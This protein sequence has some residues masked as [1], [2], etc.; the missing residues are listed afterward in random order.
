M[1]FTPRDY[2]RAIIEHALT[3][4]RANE[5]A[6]MGTGKTVSTLVVLDALYNI[7]GYS[8]PTLVLAPLRVARST[9]P[10]EV[11]KW[12]IDLT[13]SV[14][15]GNAEERERA[16]RRRAQ[17][18][19]MN[20][21]NLPWL[22]E[23]LKK[24]RMGWP[25]GNVVADESTRLKSFR[26]KQ[27][28]VRAR[29]LGAASQY[30][31]RWLNLTGT[32]SPNGLLDLWGQQWFIDQGQRLG[33]T[34]DSFKS[35][36]FHPERVGDDARA[37]K[38]IPFEHS[39]EQIQDYLRDCTLTVRAA[40]Y[41]DLPPIVHRDVR[42]QLPARAR[43]HY[44]EM[45]K[46]YFT[47]LE[48]G[49]VEAVNAASKSGKLLQFAS[50]AAYVDEHGNWEEVHDAKIEALHD[51]VAEAAGVPI[52]VAYHFKSDLARLLAAFPEARALDADPDTVRQFNRGEI[53]ILLAHP[54]S[55]G[56][57]LNLQEECWILVFFTCWWSLEHYEQ[58]IERIGPTRQFQS[59]HTERTVYVT[60]IVAEDTV[61]EL[62][63]EARETK[64]NVQEI[65]LEAM[66]R[67]KR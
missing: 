29:V 53:P 56:H 40:D 67:R 48:S 61:D 16:L 23:T 17:V 10:D 18:Y 55:A 20:Y 11:E 19:T 38:W 28:G 46:E 25:F 37:V 8:R 4:P 42:V 26:L 14:I 34:F 21:D 44:Q 6:G 12:G 39:Q 27:G 15:C 57:G 22:R 43:M 49:E 3:H 24:H 5:W 62:V 33:R 41:L 58:V 9:W 35:R 31:D 50:G 47:K 45:E 59:G 65:L 30:V 60:H 63:A 2:Q 52:I 32:P 13:V 1:N 66:K 7:D 54:Q 51:I 36:W 64:R